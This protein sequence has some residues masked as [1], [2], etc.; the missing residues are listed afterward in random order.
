MSGDNETP[1][2][3]DSGHPHLARTYSRNFLLA[4]H[5]KAA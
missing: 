4:L 1:I 5:C 2:L 3:V